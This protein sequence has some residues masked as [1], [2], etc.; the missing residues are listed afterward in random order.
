[1]SLALSD[2][3]DRELVAHRDK[4]LE[5]LGPQGH[6]GL[7]RSVRL[8][9]V[10][11]PGL[12]LLQERRVLF[13]VAVRKQTQL[14]RQSL[15]LPRS[16]VVCIG[17]CPDGTD[18]ISHLCGRLGG[19]EDINNSLLSL[20]VLVVE[21]LDLLEDVDV[22]RVLESLLEDGVLG[23]LLEEEL[24][25]GQGDALLEELK[26]FTLL[27]LEVDNL[28]LVLGLRELS[29]GRHLG[30]LLHFTRPLPD[31]V[32]QGVRVVVEERTGPLLKLVDV[33]RLLDAVRGDVRVGVHLPL[34]EGNHLLEGCLL[35]RRL[36]LELLL[37]A[38]DRVKEGKAV[39]LRVDGHLAVVGGVVQ[40]V[41]LGNPLPQDPADL[42]PVVEVQVLVHVETNLLPQ[43]V[44]EDVHHVRVG[45][46]VHLLRALQPVVLDHE[47][48]LVDV[49]DHLV[50]LLFGG[51]LR[52]LTAHT[53]HQVAVHLAREAHLQS[54]GGP[55]VVDG[56]VL[57]VMPVPRTLHV[58][59]FVR[60]AELNFREEAEL[61]G[62][63]V[64]DAAP[65]AVGIVGVLV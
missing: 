37:H 20:D 64:G 54:R 10:V 60:G 38:L 3:V 14:V 15:V 55:E 56:G 25:L 12:D 5:Q 51:I 48:L 28:I 33:V 35:T 4:G 19:H 58:V 40:P 61:V 59:N 50:L 22:V 52:H 34:V 62:H 43:W 49:I 26:E 7:E 53:V 11:A 27:L 63:L 8:R 2:L 44:G 17:R 24:L 6:A 45:E 13:R 42:L 47:L 57:V 21:G 1:M 32:D 65:P 30:L 31:V 39:L 29:E 46:P 36:A 41:L 16:D 23:H 18:V 9:V